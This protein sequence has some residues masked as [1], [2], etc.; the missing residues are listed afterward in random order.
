MSEAG[1]NESGVFLELF[2]N[3]EARLLA[4]KNGS[5]VGLGE[6]PFSVSASTWYGFR[7]RVQGSQA[8]GRIWPLSE[9]EPGGW[10]FTSGNVG[11]VPTGWP[12][13]GCFSSSGE[14]DLRYFEVKELIV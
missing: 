4:Y 2:D 14:P 12:G 6:V 9:S 13:V 8:R 11:D 5:T 7:L 3:D 10:T 1:T